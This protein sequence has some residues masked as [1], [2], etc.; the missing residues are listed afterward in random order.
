MVCL[1]K[2]T[3]TT[4]DANGCFC[5]NSNASVDGTKCKFLYKCINHACI[6]LPNCSSFKKTLSIECLCKTLD[7]IRCGIN[8][9]ESC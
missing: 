9:N 5:A 6:K 3:S 4:A 1:K 2:C 8:V 7:S